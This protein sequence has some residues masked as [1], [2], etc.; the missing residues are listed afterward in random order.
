MSYKYYGLHSKVQR[1]NRQLSYYLKIKN[2]EKALE[3]EE[4]IIQD[5]LFISEIRQ[6]RQEFGIYENQLYPNLERLS[7]GDV[8]SWFNSTMKELAIDK[9][10]GDLAQTASDI[11]AR[12]N[13]P[14]GWSDYVS[15]YICLNDRPLNIAIEPD[16][17]I[18]IVGIEH[19]DSLMVRIEKGLTRSDY[20][21]AWKALDNYLK[22]LTP[23]EHTG[24]SLKYRILL[25]NVENNMSAGKLAK[26]Y[27][28]I[29]TQSLTKYEIISQSQLN[30]DRV[31]KILKRMKN[32]D[33][34]VS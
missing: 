9:D 12:L 24:D 15:A 23:I 8:Y 22:E 10:F 5:E 6:A 21:A 32:R 26:K 11:C 31:K 27:F 33:K 25:D 16:L 18:D 13:L 4:Y 14:Y 34:K 3:A 2:Q 19:D 29:D 7:I 28:P 30:R 20:I 1:W 17:K